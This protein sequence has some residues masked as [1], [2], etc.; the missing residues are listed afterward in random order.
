MLRRLRLVVI[1]GSAVVVLAFG[2]IALN[3]APTAA[4]GAPGQ[5]SDRPLYVRVI[6]AIAEAIPVE[7]VNSPKVEVA[8]RQP[9]QQATNNRPG[10]AVE[11]TNFRIDVPEGKRLVIESASVYVE[12]PR[13]QQ[14]MAHITGN[15]P[16]GTT[17]GL[18]HLVLQKQGTFDGVDVYTA[19]HSML[20]WVGQGDGN[21]H[22]K[23]SDTAGVMSVETAVV[24]YL[25]EL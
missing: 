19:N 11:F 18:Q 1:G 4:Q 2:F 23:R 13:G 6:N 25:E 8:A 22:V 9:F 12:V 10:H 16:P 3:A 14:V 24:G 21:F 7:V 15:G 20:L 17:L 5:D